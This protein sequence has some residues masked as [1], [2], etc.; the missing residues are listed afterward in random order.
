MG[1]RADL[2]RANKYYAFLIRKQTNGWLKPEM[3]LGG[4]SD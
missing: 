3:E 2:L 1:T 4:L